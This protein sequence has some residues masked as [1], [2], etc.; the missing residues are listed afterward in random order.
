M[1]KEE[2]ESVYGQSVYEIQMNI[3]SRAFSLMVSN[4][5]IPAEFSQMAVTALNA[6]RE[7]AATVLANPG[8][9]IEPQG[10]GRWR[11]PASHSAKH[12]AASGT[13]GD[14]PH[15]IKGIY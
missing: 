15:R 10:I 2:V 13:V 9:A 1:T 14:L 8:P 11:K 7:F 6:S 5:P 3:A 4:R 12:G